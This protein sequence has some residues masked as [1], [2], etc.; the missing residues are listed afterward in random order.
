MQDP[1]KIALQKFDENSAN[2]RYLHWKLY[3]GQDAT[4]Q[5]N[6]CATSG[7][8]VDFD[9][10][11]SRKHLQRSLEVLGEG[12]YLI[13]YKENPEKSQTPISYRFTIGYQDAAIGAGRQQEQGG[14]NI[15]ANY[16]R[17][18]DVKQLV[19]AEIGKVTATM[20]KAQLL[21]ENEELVKELKELRKKNSG[22]NLNEA[23]A[24]FN[25]MITAISGNKPAPVNGPRVSIAKG[26]DI[27][28][29]AERLQQHYQKI[30]LK[31]L[32]EMQ[33]RAGGAYENIDLLFCL[34]EWIKENPALYESLKPQIMKYAARL[35]R[36]TDMEG[37]G[38][39]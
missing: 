9:R 22:F 26:E 8:I 6:L 31:V 10:D 36:F 12:D 7:T 38:N 20:E 4:K 15:P 5:S 13:Q 19:T 37:P 2:N 25:A 3:Y 33:A 39:G 16:M 29:D 17:A 27:D 30:Y 34:N 35:P 23:L 18:E 11:S 32:E 21:K 1:R 14:N 28:P 24:Q